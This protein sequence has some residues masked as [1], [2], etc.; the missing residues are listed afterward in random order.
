MPDNE[1]SPSAV[2]LIIAFA[3][4][5]VVVTTILIAYQLHK[6]DDGVPLAENNYPVCIQKP[7]AGS[8]IFRYPPCHPGDDIGLIDGE[9]VFHFLPEVPDDDKA[10]AM[11]KLLKRLFPLHL[12]QSLSRCYVCGDEGEDGDTI[13]AGG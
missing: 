6:P 10:R 7:E 4:A 5:L 13:H 8:D 2:H 12:K 1:H 3:I 11:G 9:G